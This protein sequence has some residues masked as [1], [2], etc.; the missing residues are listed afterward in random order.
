M[1]YLHKSTKICAGYILDYPKVFCVHLTIAKGKLTHWYDW[2][3]DAL[4]IAYICLDMLVFSACVNIY[5]DL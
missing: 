1:T 3:I 2:Y 5:S 4:L